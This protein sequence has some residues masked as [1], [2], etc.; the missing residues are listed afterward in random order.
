MG[1]FLTQQDA[2]TQNTISKECWQ[3]STLEHQLFTLT[4]AWLA[5]SCSLLLLT[6]ITREYHTAYHQPRKMSEFKVQFLLNAYHFCTIVKSKHLKSDHHKSGTICIQYS[7]ISSYNFD[8]Y[9]FTLNADRI[10][11]I[12]SPLFCCIQLAVAFS[13]VI[14]NNKMLFKNSS[15]F[16]LFPVCDSL[17]LFSNYNVFLNLIE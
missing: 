15:V 10:L 9:I 12:V 14:F 4:I 5:G 8:L 13:Q 11:Q 3:H 2:K 1:I 6:S 16:T 17:P 7:L